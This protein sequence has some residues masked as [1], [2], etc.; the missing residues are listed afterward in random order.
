MWGGKCSAGSKHHSA[1]SKRHEHLTS[2]CSCGRVVWGAA[3]G[4]GDGGKEGGGAEGVRGGGAL[5]V[6]VVDTEDAGA[7]TA[8]LEQL[9]IHAPARGHAHD[10]FVWRA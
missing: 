10:W 2:I 4:G 7:G 1:K 3:G 8:L 6:G 9:A 5:L